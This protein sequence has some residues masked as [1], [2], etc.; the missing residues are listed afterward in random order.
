MQ[1]DCPPFPPGPLKDSF[2][3]PLNDPRRNLLYGWQIT[4]LFGGRPNPFTGRP[5]NHGGMDL[6]MP[7]GVPFIQCI[8]GNTYQSWDSG[9]G[10][11]WTTIY[12][13]G[14][15]A[16]VGYGHAQR[17]EPGVNNTF[18]KPGRVIAYCDSTGSSTGNHLH[19]ALDNED[20]DGAYNDPFDPLYEVC[21]RF[22]GGGGLP[23]VIT[24]PPP[25]QE[26]DM[27]EDA[28]KK[29]LE[30]IENTVA[31]MSANIIQT[32]G[33]FENDTRVILIGET[34]ALVTQG[35]KEILAAIHSG[36]FDSRDFAFMYDGKP[37]VYMWVDT[38]TGRMRQWIG[39]YKAGTT[40]P[41]MDNVDV[42]GS[43]ALLTSLIQTKLN[44]MIVVL[45]P[46][47]EKVHDSF[48]SVIGP[49]PPA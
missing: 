33:S 39:V 13:P 47:L 49:K 45:E 40:E 29:R 42:P 22:A 24:P 12:L 38:P 20:A 23:P 15:N 7:L 44:P 17:F 25:T 1:L 6:G 34:K 32:L 11:N 3:R 19:F 8:P 28:D 35:D 48:A 46:D 36:K 41:K 30:R 14:A 21:Y 16:R 27:F 43:Q 5:S 2:G 4:S 31:P 26:D 10:G 18:G 37:A 9:G